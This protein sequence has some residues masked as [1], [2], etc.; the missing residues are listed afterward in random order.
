M[1][2]LLAKLLVL[3][4]LILF[5]QCSKLGYIDRRYT[6]GH[7]KPNSK[8][9]TAKTGK[10]KTIEMPELDTKTEITASTKT[11]VE[12]KETEEV[13][14]STKKEVIVKPS[15]K[16]AKLIDFNFISKIDKNDIDA[17][18][19]KMLARMPFSASLIKKKTEAEAK[20]DNGPA[21]LNMILS[22]VGFASA[23][24][25]IILAFVAIFD[26]LIARLSTSTYISPLF[27]V[28]MV[29]GLIA[30]AC[31]ITTL[32]MGKGELESY[33][34]SFAILAI[35]FGGV[36]ILIAALWSLLFFSI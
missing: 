9:T 18:K 20:G 12:L 26:T 30:M 14:A 25:A 11:P 34:K 31:G 13:T 8:S 32:I 2:K 22:I 15:V 36:A 28:A 6:K 17:R 27:V 19:A 23:I 5:A 24:V 4:V 35:V 7:Y 1:S 29:L 16:K 21:I 10:T 33:Q 3:S